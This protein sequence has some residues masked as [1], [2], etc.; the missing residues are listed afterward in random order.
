MTDEPAG[1]PGASLETLLAALSG[2]EVDDAAAEAA[3]VACMAL[4]ADESAVVFARMT[5]LAAA[6]A[7]DRRWWALRALAIL[8]HVDPAP[9]LI[10][11]LHDPDAAVRQCAALGLRRHPDWRAV[12]ALAAALSDL[13]PLAARLAGDALSAIGAEA[14]PVLIELLSSEN[15]PGAAGAFQPATRLGALRALAAIGDPRAIPVLFAALDGS[16]LEEYW[17]GAGLERLG[18]GM[19]FF[20]PG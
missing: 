9:Q 10:A 18:V 16:T 2:G 20:N 12:A 5:A 8:P 14:V 19:S 15:P 17:A 7:P 11:A 6:P 13:D 3:L 4:P 1:A